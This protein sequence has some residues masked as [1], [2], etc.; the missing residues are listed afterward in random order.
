[1]KFQTVVCY[2]IAVL[3]LLHIPTLCKMAGLFEQVEGLFG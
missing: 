2:I 1:M 3:M